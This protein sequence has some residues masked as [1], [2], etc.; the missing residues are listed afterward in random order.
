MLRRLS[1]LGGISQVVN[2]IKPLR[3]SGTLI[4]IKFMKNYIIIVVII[5]I[6][7]VRATRLSERISSLYRFS[8]MNPQKYIS[9]VYDLWNRFIN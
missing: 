7:P 6:P 2:N 5:V 8:R 3:K 9:L 4:Y 1:N